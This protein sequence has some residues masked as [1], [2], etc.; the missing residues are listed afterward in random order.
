MWLLDRL[1]C[2]QDSFSPERWCY[3]V[4]DACYQAA[5]E[6][7][8][9]GF[10]KP[11]SLEEQLLILLYQHMI[12]VTPNQ[13]L[14]AITILD[15]DVFNG[16][17]P[18]VTYAQSGPSSMAQRV[19]EATFS[20]YSTST[21]LDTS[22]QSTIIVPRRSIETTLSTQSN[23]QRTIIVP[24]RSEEASRRSSADRTIRK[25]KAEKAVRQDEGRL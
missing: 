2:R 21:Q 11:D 3:E 4:S 8:G 19:N 15:D 6:S 24:R 9:W 20:E 14:D 5:F 12:Q 16:V 7:E 10:N 23:S 22:T 18:Q 13:R 17:S 1:P 25:S